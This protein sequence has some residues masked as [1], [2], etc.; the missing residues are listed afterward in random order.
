[1]VGQESA[2]SCKMA[3]CL[4]CGQ[5][6]EKMLQAPLSHICKTGNLSSGPQRK[7]NINI[8]LR[9]TLSNTT[10]KTNRKTWENQLQNLKWSLYKAWIKWPVSGCTDASQVLLCLFWIEVYNHICNNYKLSSYSHVWQDK[11]DC[12]PP[13]CPTVFSRLVV[14]LHVSSLTDD[15]QATDG[16]GRTGAAT[17]RQ[18]TGRTFLCLLQKY[19]THTIRKR[20]FS[21]QNLTAYME[22]HVF[23]P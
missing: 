8:A 20:T 6:Y 11:V 21:N 23:L 19:W 17:K 3:P 10:S 2:V 14:D 12:F 1:M 9:M 5:E 15:Q 13:R 18:D 7:L 4:I 22:N 16:I